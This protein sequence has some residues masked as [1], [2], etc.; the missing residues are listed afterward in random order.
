MLWASPR[1]VY[2]IINASNANCDIIT[3]QS[4]LIKKMSLFGKKSEE[5]SLDTV[6]MFFNDATESE[7]IL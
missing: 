1:M 7:Y 4:S 6:K 2:D 3:M 5:Y